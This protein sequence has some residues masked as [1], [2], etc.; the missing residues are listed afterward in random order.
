MK[1]ILWLL[2][3]GLTARLV[4]EEPL[5]TVQMNRANGLLSDFQQ[6]LY[7][8]FVAS[9]A[10]ETFSRSKLYLKF[11]EAAAVYQGLSSTAF[12]LDQLRRLARQR[13]LLHLYNVRELQF[14]AA[15]EMEEKDYQ[16]SR[17]YLERA[18]FKTFAH[19]GLNYFLRTDEE[20]KK[21]FCF[22][23]AHR[24]LLLSNSPQVMESQLEKLQG[25]GKIFS[26]DGENLAEKDF[27]IFMRFTPAF[28]DSPYIQSYWFNPDILRL[29]KEWQSADVFL[30]AA[31]QNISETR[32]YQL[33]KSPEKIL[34]LG[35]ESIP[36]GDLILMSSDPGEIDLLLRDFVAADRPAGLIRPQKVLL[37]KKLQLDERLLLHNRH[38]LKLA[39]SGDE[40]AKRWKDFLSGRLELTSR[41]LERLDI[42]QKG[43][44]VL[45]RSPE[46]PEYHVKPLSENIIAYG[47]LN[48]DN[49]IAN[50]LGEISAAQASPDFYLDDRGIFNDLI[51][52]LLGIL[53]RVA[54]I[55]KYSYCLKQLLKQT[56]VYRLKNPAGG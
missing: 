16:L 44:V 28:L 12:R 53:R 51:K 6:T 56:V 39:C 31:P 29:K 32:Y 13:A 5:L 22:F 27:D 26:S 24:L 52:P 40:E 25:G 4:A 35:G 41:Y 21:Y 10:E 50:S 43:S 36:D 19:A 34:S 42:E 20:G 17:F 8:D 47:F 2:L 3:L 9:K 45:L 23:F 7:R 11:T 33:K 14:F 1:K 48:L 18:K 54:S 49:V 15:L 38:W 30:K 46:S 55:E 37:V